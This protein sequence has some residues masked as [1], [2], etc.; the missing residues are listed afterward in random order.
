MSFAG[1]VRIRVVAWRV[2]PSRR[3]EPEPL[4]PIVEGR[5]AAWALREQVRARAVTRDV[6][7]LVDIDSRT[8][9]RCRLPDG[10]LGR[11]AIVMDGGGP[12]RV[13]QVARLQKVRG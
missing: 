6:H 11:V 9:V 13:C 8:D 4:A 7:F 3:R 1:A 12:T 10:S 2:Q 5:W